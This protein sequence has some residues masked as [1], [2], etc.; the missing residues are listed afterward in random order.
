[1]GSTA[2]AT[3][4]VDRLL[5]HAHVV[6]TSTIATMFGINHLGSVW[7]T[8]AVAPIFVWEPSLG[9]YL[10]VKGF[11]PSPI[12]ARMAAASIP[13]A[14]VTW[15]PEP[16]SLA[17]RGSFTPSPHI[18]ARKPVVRGRS[19]P[20][21]S[22]TSGSILSLWPALGEPANGQ[23]SADGRGHAQDTEG[24]D[25]R[26]AKDG[27]KD[28]GRT[29]RLRTVTGAGPAAGARHFC[30]ERCRSASGYP[31]WIAALVLGMATVSWPVR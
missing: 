24:A 30:R 12:T 4:T 21:P 20:G 15:M 16:P 26:R 23:N 8:I 2:T 28:K 29:A 5:H 19:P 17:L 31:T 7:S 1:V 3:A 11:K 9:V 27:A 10:V 13:P 22:V 6:L 25:D 18:S 14:Y